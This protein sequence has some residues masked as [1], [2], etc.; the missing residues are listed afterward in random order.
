MTQQEKLNKLTEGEIQ[1]LISEY[2]NDIQEYKINFLID[3]KP[4]PYARARLGRGKRF[5]NPASSIENE[6]KLNCE[7]Q[8]SPEHREIL[9]KLLT[10]ETA[11][12]N[13]KISGNF[14]VKIPDNDSVKNTILKEK[15]IIRPKIRNGDIDNY[16]KL[17]LDAL[18]DVLYTDDKI[19][20]SIVAEKYYSINPRSEIEV[21]LYIKSF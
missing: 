15:G 16:M 18:H 1:K 5:Y 7:H 20:T 9:S 3:S 4:K 13:V 14:F 10:S 17:L 12:Y 6:I 19:V 8:L 21:T 11:D 2:N